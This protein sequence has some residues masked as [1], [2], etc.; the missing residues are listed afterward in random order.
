MRREKQILREGECE[1]HRLQL[2]G[3]QNREL[4]GRMEENRQCALDHSG[5][6]VVEQNG[7]EQ[8]VVGTNI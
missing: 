8:S 5:E 4:S 6:V 3:K 1:G 2:T 7:S